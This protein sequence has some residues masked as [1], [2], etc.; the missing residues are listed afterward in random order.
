MVSGIAPDWVNHTS[1][2]AVI[3]E[4]MFVAHSSSLS[5]YYCS[6]TC[7]KNP[8][9]TTLETNQRKKNNGFEFHQSNSMKIH[10]KTNIYHIQ[11]HFCHAFCPISLGR[12]SSSSARALRKA[13]W[14]RLAPMRIASRRRAEVGK[15]Q[16]ENAP[17]K[18]IGKP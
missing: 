15:S 13:L 3:A 12:L 16:A 4:A 6:P 8:S 1:S 5:L 7:I 2:A 18:T 14:P 10:D 17:M 9:T 11:A